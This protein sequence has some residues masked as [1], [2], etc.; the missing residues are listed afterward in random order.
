LWDGDISANY[1]PSALSKVPF[2]W[3]YYGERFEYEFI[4]GIVGATQNRDDLTV[5]PKIGWAVVDLSNEQKPDKVKK[6]S[7]SF[8]SGDI[9]VL[10]SVPSSGFDLPIIREEIGVVVVNDYGINRI[11]VGDN[12]NEDRKRESDSP[13]QSR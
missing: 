1:L 5:C 8:S 6:A 10:D 3:D 13:P 11:E 7:E 12:E 4:A 9:T 2:I